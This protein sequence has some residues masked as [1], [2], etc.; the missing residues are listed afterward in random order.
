MSVLIRRAWILVAI[1]FAFPLAA[2]QEQPAEAPFVQSADGLTGYLGVV[3][4]AIVQ[5]HAPEHEERR[6]HASEPRGGAHLVIAIFDDATGDRVED[7]AVEAIVR[8]DRHRAG[9]RLRLEPMRIEGALTYGGFI[10]LARN[11]RYHI[12]IVVRRAGLNRDAYLRYVFDAA[13]LPAADIE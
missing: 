6:M 10:S 11:D 3:P 7:A 13:S 12:N 1:A 8:G 2:C 4:R 5:V 9:R